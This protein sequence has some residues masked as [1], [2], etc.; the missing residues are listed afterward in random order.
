MRSHSI[1]PG[2][3]VL[4]VAAVLAAPAALSATLHAGAASVSITPDKPV[5]LAGQMS[6]RIAREVESELQANALAIDR[7]TCECSEPTIFVRVTRDVPRNAQRAVASWYAPAD[8]DVN[9]LIISATHTHTS[10]VMK[11]DIYVIPGEDVMRPSDYAE[12]FAVR[13]ADAAEA[14]WKARQPAKAGWGMGDAVIGYNRRSFFKD[15]HGQMYGDISI[16][17]F[18]GIEGPEDHAVEVLFFWGEDDSLLA[19]AVN[20]ACTAQEVEGLSVVNADFWH[21]VREGLQAKHGENRSCW[22]DW[23]RGPVRRTSVYRPKPPRTG[24]RQLRA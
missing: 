24:M 3:W 21:P 5:A 11:E 4:G 13:V 1:V 17:E 2:F 12:F 10:L 22:L 7:G 20:M 23:G 16:D 18:R 8:F 19:T 15:G 14:A 9:K 6:T